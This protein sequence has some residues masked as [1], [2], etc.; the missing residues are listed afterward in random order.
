MHGLFTNFKD[1]GQKYTYDI[2]SATENPDGSSND[3]G[4]IT[5]S[6]SVRRPNYQISDLILGGNHVFNHSY[7]HYVAAI[8]HSREGGA[9]GNP[10][11]DFTPLNTDPICRR[12][13]RKHVRLYSRPEHLPAAVPLRGKRSDLQRLTVCP[14]GH[15]PHH[16][17][18]DAAQS[19]GKRLNRDQLPSG[20][21]HFDTSSLAPWS[22]T[23][24][25]DSTRFR[26]L[27]IASASQCH[28][29]AVDPVYDQ[30]YKSKFLWREL[31]ISGRSPTFDSDYEMARTNPG[32]LPLDEA[33]T[34]LNSDPA[35][36]NLQERITAGYVMNTVDLG[37]KFHLQT[38]LR[39]E[40]TNEHNTGYL[41]NDDTNGN[42]VSTNPVN[43]GGSYINLLPS[44]QLRYNIDQNSDLRAVYGH[45]DFPARPVRPGALSRH[46]MSRRPRIPKTSATPLWLRN[47][48]KTLISSMRGSCRLLE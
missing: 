41:V 4:G 38:G 32:A 18:G 7:H 6:T 29:A 19:A 15:Q 8:S 26:Q 22:A 30:F 39:I 9:A 48:P 40:A 3:D 20:F 17:A 28:A 27:T 12:R 47:T 35:N 11:A 24:I 2:V 37:S 23:R 25:K 13:A 43:G 16:R 34:H 1:Y 33:A 46:W 10:G 42:Y 21:A 45:G 36:Y 14:A 44:V 5:Y 31:Q